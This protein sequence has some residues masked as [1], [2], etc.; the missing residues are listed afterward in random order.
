MDDL[1][2]P[3]FADAASMTLYQADV[4]SR[5]LTPHRGYDPPRIVVLADGPALVVVLSNID[6][7]TLESLALHGIG[8]AP[9]LQ[10]QVFF[11]E[12]ASKLGGFVLGVETIPSRKIMRGWT[13]RASF[14]VSRPG[15]YPS[16]DDCESRWTIAVPFSSFIAGLSKKD[17]DDLSG[18]L[19]HA[20][21]LQH[22]LDDASEADR[23][24]DPVKTQE[25]EEYMLQALPSIF[26]RHWTRV[27]R[28]IAPSGSVGPSGK[29]VY[30]TTFYRA[31][32]SIAEDGLRPG[33][34]GM[35]IFAPGNRTG[36]YVSDFNGVRFWFN[37]AVDFAEYSSDDPFAE[38]L[39][40]VVLRVKM[41][42][43]GVSRGCRIDELGAS[44]SYAE[45]WVCAVPIP[46]ALIDA[47]TGEEWVPIDRASDSINPRRGTRAGE[48]GRE[49][50]RGGDSPL[51]P[52]S[53]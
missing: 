49:L 14:P 23:E 46:P 18:R 21:S 32:E 10:E 39:V 31:L 37:K 25:L 42:R 9:T 52:E 36:V 47:W 53:P 12:F 4:R 28:R 50:L 30:H 7:Y 22:W 13:E 2:P 15:W 1:T 3:R 8:C 20:M 40:P 17:R 19:Y 38:G 24:A 45:A 5:M 43:G 41:P 34:R 27:F 33:A 26:L 6:L 35:T 44:D 16:E 51:R 48:Y 11:Q 29:T